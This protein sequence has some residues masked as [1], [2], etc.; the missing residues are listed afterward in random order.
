VGTFA[1]Q[2][3]KSLGA[4]V[5]GV[6][7]TRN[8]DLVR[9][10]GAD[11][12]IDYTREDFTKSGQRYDMILDLVG[13]HSTS[14]FRRAL[15]PKGTLVL[16]SGNGGRWLG[17]MGRIINAL[18]LSPFVGQRLRPLVATRSKE[19]LV[20]LKELMESGR[21]TPVIDRTYPLGETPE[22]IRYVEEGH[23]RGKVVIL[24]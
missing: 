2:I 15:T 18:V 24:V 17:P 5:T 11:H 19:N 6:C 13:N 8:V 9:S 23:A 1:V 14:D 10:I 12:V 3:A 22:A 21:V 7:S 16:S 20:A 4:E